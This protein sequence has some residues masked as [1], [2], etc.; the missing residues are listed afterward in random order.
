[1][2]KITLISLMFCLFAT[3]A[4]S[5][6]TMSIPLIGD[7]APSFTAE[8]TNGQ[9]TF[10]GDYGKNWKI[11]F[12]HPKDFTPV[13][14]SELL[15][16][17]N[18]QSDFE[19][20]GVKLVVL[21]T[22]KLSQHKLWKESLE[23]IN[24][25]GVAPQ[26]IKFPLVEDE[27]YNISKLYGMLHAGTSTTKDVRGV[28]IINPDNIVEAVYFYPMSIGRNMDEIKRTVIALQTAQ[29]NI[30]TPANWQPGDDVIL[31][32]LTDEEKAIMKKANATIYEVAWYMIFKKMKS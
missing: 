14:S 31:S 30:L 16:L 7:K 1:M 11:L 25:Q 2:K 10:P 28:F 12:S 6:N 20:L 18:M 8:S 23:S 3:S 15:E 22:D 13:C 29:N 9:I 17:A 32:Y 5:Q 21:S 19:Q 4:W 24:Y 26:K 27:T